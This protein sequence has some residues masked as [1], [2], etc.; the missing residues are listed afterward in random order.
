[1]REVIIP[2]K[3]DTKDVYFNIFRGNHGLFTVGETETRALADEE[4][5]VLKAM[6][7]STRVGRIKVT[8]EEGKWDE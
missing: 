6:S 8:L 4:A 1:M 2:K 3:I 7:G 5:D